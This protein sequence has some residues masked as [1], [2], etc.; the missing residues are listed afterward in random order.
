[1]ALRAAESH[2]DAMWGGSPELRRTPS[3]GFRA[4]STERCPTPILPGKPALVHPAP[5][6][7]TG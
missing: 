7:H 4:S 6:R 2:E 5:K 1:M 3:S